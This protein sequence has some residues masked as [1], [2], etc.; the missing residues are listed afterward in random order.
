MVKSLGVFDEIFWFST[1][2]LIYYLCIVIV[3]N[4]LDNQ[5]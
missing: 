5:R 4:L 1:K 3:S 2:F